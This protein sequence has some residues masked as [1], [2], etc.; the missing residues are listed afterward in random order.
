MSLIAW[1]CR[2]AGGRLTVNYMKK[3]VRKFH[4]SV[5]FL[6]ETKKQMDY[7]EGKRKLLKFQQ[8]YYVH[9]VERAGGLALW[10]IADLPIRVISCSRFYIDVFISI[11]DGFFCTFVHAPSTTIERRE[12]WRCISSLRTNNNEPWLVIGDCNAVCF[13]YEKVGRNPIRY[14]S[15]QPFRDFIF[16]N[17][18]MDLG[19]KGDPLTWTNHQVEPYLVKARLD[20]A[21]CNPRWQGMF[22][23][24]VLHNEDRIGSDHAPI[25]LLFEGIKRVRG[26]FRF[27]RR[28][29]NNQE[30][31]DII[32]TE[33]DKGGSCI[34]R[35][36]GCQETLSLWARNR[37][38][39]NKVKEEELKVRL[40]FLNSI[41][42]DREVVEEE[43]KILD[44]LEKLWSD[45]EDFW[46]QRAGAHWLR[47]GDRNTRFFHSSTQFRRQRNNISRLQKDN[48]MWE[49]NANRLK[50]VAVGYFRSLFTKSSEVLMDD[51]LSYFPRRHRER[52]GYEPP[53]SRK[54][55]TIIDPEKWKI[56]KVIYIA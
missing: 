52:C 56:N 54:P 50:D 47:M 32:R 18:L 39:C 29:S 9:P 51:D 21:L 10:W 46:K 44:E 14:G 37:H 6:M 45:E 2:G 23:R 36:R 43:H 34:T 7:M 41:I 40:R 24:A 22:G 26:P 33:W 19:C 8:C 25:R 42:R 3:M 38:S 30:C 17:S 11:G 16:A 27:D 31:K 28:W 20:R 49:V 35:L 13:D 55:A 4:P 5:L 48:G 53:P 15:T 1:N 12:F